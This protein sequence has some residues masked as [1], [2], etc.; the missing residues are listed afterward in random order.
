MKID[1]QIGGKK[2]SVSIERSAGLLECTI[3]GRKV[4]AHAAEVSPGFYSLLIG[5]RSFEVLVQP[6]SA[7]LTVLVGS[8]EYEISIL[9]RREWRKGQSAA[10]EKEGRERIMA[11]MPGKVVRV[12]VKNGDAIKKGQ[13]ILVVEAMKMQN[14]IRAAKSGTIERLEVAEGQTV[15]AGQVLGIIS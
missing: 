5:G 3:D 9:D 7:D 14:E 1:L 4:N 10:A 13:G 2:R 12:L 11:S 15:S 8:R 6:N